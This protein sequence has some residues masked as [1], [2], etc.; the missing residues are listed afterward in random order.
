M[1]LLFSHWVVCNSATPWTAPCQASLFSTISWGLLKFMSIESVMLSNHRI[2]CYHLL[3]FLLS[4]FPS[5]KVFSSELTLHIRWSKYW[6]FSNSRNQGWFPLRL[7]VLMSLQSRDPQESSPA[8]QF[9]NI[10]SLV[11]SFLY[12]PALRSI[13]DYWKNHSFDC[14][15]LRQQWYLCV[16]SL[17]AAKGIL[18]YVGLVLCLEDGDRG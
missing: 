4:V 6:S 16:L 8:L 1:S 11:L 9:E 17:W 3:L 14:K 7:T 10:S 12:G 13:H 18:K 5:I 15:D 2:L